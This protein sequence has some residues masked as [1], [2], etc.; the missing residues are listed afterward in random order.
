M[1]KDPYSSIE[2][3][4]L[5][6]FEAM[7]RHGSLTQA[8]IELGISDAAVSQRIRSLE[9][10]LGI[11][12]YEARGGKVRLTQKGR[13]TKALAMR[14]FDEFAEF[15]SDIRGEEF[16]GTIVLSALSYVF[17]YQLSEIVGSFRKQHR[18]AKLRLVSQGI[19]ETIELVRQN[20]V[21]V[22]LISQRREIS[23]DLVFHRWRTFKV[24]LLIPR[25]HPLVRRKV[26][27]LHDIL[28]EE[29]LLRYPQVTTGLDGS[30]DR[31]K[32]TLERLGLPFNVSVEVGDIDTMKHYVSQGHGLAVLNGACLTQEDKAL[33]HMIEIPD[34]FEHETN[35]GVLLRRD[36][37]IS[38]ALR[39]LLDLL[40]VPNIKNL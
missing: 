21:D 35:Y 31:V 11:K 25:D 19:P 34:E 12:L 5:L 29:T 16:Q 26:P 3:K 13:R 27:T 1:S 38:P 15:E 33:F 4:A 40:G 7:A 6:C 20:E 14:I 17:R 32:A 36:K 30:E 23:P 2:M 9:N 24:Y 37:Y 10:Y 18:L 22:G 28:N 39:T 8:S